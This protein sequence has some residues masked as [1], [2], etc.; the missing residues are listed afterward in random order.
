MHPFFFFYNVVTHIPHE[1]KSYQIKICQQNV[2]N[3]HL[4][5]LPSRVLRQIIFLATC[6]SYSP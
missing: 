1:K 6:D 3:S 2:L 5:I 4:K